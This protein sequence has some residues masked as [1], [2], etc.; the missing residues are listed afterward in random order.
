MKMGAMAEKEF[1]V[2]V[3]LADTRSAG[4]LI[5]IAAALMPVQSG[6][7]RGRVVALG[8]VEIPEEMDFS[9]GVRPAQ[10]HRQQ[11]GRAFKKMAGSPELEI[12]TLVR[13]S[14]QVWQGI[15]DAAQ[16][17]QSDLL[18][19]SWKGSTE[20][21]DRIF[22]TT[23]DQIVK[24]PPCDI[25]LVRQLPPGCYKRI[26]LP[27]RG[28]PH[29]ALALRLAIGLAERNDG[30]VTALRIIPPGATLEEVEQQKE[31]FASFLAESPSP[32]VQAVYQVADSVAEAILRESASHDLVMMGA[33]GHRRRADDGVRRHVDG[34]C[35]DARRRDRVSGEAARSP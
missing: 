10:A 17:E 19:L 35:R 24:D 14:R 27:V 23:I 4:D 31:H 28:G 12:G 32:R 26:L 13:V 25:A 20:T 3:P 6:K 30:T 7:R 11:F 34:H 2:L 8:I 21:P 29:A 33:A 5:R 15:A 1:K 22:G 9:Q 18:L 16:E